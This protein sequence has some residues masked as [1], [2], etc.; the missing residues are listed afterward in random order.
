MKSSIRRP[1]EPRPI[2]P[3]STADAASDIESHIRLKELLDENHA[4]QG[5]GSSDAEV[6]ADLRV[7]RLV[8]EANFFYREDLGDSPARASVDW[9]MLLHQKSRRR[10][11]WWA[12][13]SLVA[14]GLC[15]TALSWMS[16]GIENHRQFQDG[17]DE[18]SL[19]K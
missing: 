12:L 2:E 17:G 19:V 7:R 11:W 10:L 1:I 16:K 4:R 3:R 14:L 6:E 8:Q 5:M 15:A 13:G 18:F 9:D